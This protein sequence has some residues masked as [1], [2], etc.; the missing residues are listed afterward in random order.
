MRRFPARE[1]RCRFWSLEEAS[2]GAVPFQ[3]AKWARLANRVMSPMS[4]S[5]RG[6]AGRTD[7]VQIL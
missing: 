1:S 3:E 7:A 2:N 4:P 5:S 6:G